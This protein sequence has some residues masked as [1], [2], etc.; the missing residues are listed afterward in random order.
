M[1]P[2]TR[3]RALQGAAG[4][5]ASLAG[6]ADATSESGQSSGP[7][8]PENVE[9]DPEHRVLRGPNGGESA[10]VWLAP[11][12]PTASGDSPTDRQWVHRD[13][14][15]T[16]AVADRLAFA[17]VDGAA[18]AKE[19]VDGTDF[20]TETLLVL[21]EHVPECHTLELCHVTWSET[22]YHAYYARHYRDW[23][24]PCE[25]DANDRQVFLVR[26]PDTL[27]PEEVTGS[28]SGTTSGTCYGWE[29]RLERRREAAE[30]GQNETTGD[31][32]AAGRT[33]GR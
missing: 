24:V 4:F 30:D 6:C 26:L 1:V 3:R 23:E 12:T 27:D 10:A 16:R 15:A 21:P 20:E 29:R 18:E 17:D 9:H 32:S 33:G 13:V 11:E 25:T 2:L 14:I 7:R 22:D 28:G 19:F 8:T 31:E 5:L